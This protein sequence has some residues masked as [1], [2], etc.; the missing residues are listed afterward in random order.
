MASKFFSKLIKSRAPIW[1]TVLQNCRVPEMHPRR[2]ILGLVPP[3]QYDSTWSKKFSLGYLMSSAGYEILPVLGVTAISISFVVFSV[4]YAIKT[5]VDVVFKTHCR[6][7]ISRTMDL[8]HPRI[9]K[10]IVIDQ[11]YEPWPEM[12]NVL[13]LMNRAEYKQCGQNH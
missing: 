10:L 12:A 11:T 1:C 2:T 4:C 3:T 6:N 9:L 5:K 8:N 7:N 13:C